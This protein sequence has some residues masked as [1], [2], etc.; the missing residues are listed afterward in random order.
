MPKKSLRLVVIGGVAAGTRGASKARRDDPSME[1][2]ILTEEPYISYAGCGLA[3]Y[4]GGV[5]EDRSRLFARSPE[6]FREKQDIDVL[7]RHRAERID[8]YDRVVHALDLDSGGRRMM[9]F[10]RLLIATGAS[11]VMPPVGGADLDGVFTLHTI[12]DAE[13]IRSWLESRPAGNACVLGGGYIGLEAAENLA[14]R[15]WSVRVFELEDT[16][17][18]RMLE[19][20]QASM[21]EKHLAEKGVEVHTGTN[22]AA[23]SADGNGA[24]RAVEA[25][26]R[27]HP[28]EIAIVAAGVAPRV[29]LAKDAR[30]T[31]GQTGAIRVDDKMETNVRGVYAAGDCAE[32]T[33]LVSGAPFWMPLGSTANKMGR[34]AGANIAG[35]SKR[36]PGVLGTSIVKVFDLDVGATGLTTEEA[37]RAGFNPVTAA[38][39]SPTR[40]GYYPGGE[41]LSVTVTADRGSRRILGVRAVGRGSVDK[42]VDTAAA[43]LY[44]RLTIEQMTALDLAYSPPYSPALGALIVAGQVLEGK[45]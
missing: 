41:T 44:G 1:I 22:I 25:G 28:C 3:Y 38:I 16:V 36:F 40:P 21:V 17:L 19:P 18:P 42:I 31:I 35:G 10:D 33:H 27:T 11:A 37:T 14:A 6:T 26:G 39:S 9:P 2:T 32:T 15:G 23:F 4:F 5:V 24:V 34:V 20:E 7:L 8:T 13:N 45:M 30:I 12:P 29:E 43:A